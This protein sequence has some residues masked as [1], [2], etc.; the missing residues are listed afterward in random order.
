MTAAAVKKSPQPSP[1]CREAVRRVMELMAIRGVSGEETEVVAYL[2]RALLKA[3]LPARSI[4]RDTAHKKSPF[5]GAEG[6]LIIKLPGTY[7]APRRLFMAHLDTVPVCLGSKPVL[8]E[9][10]RRIRS[11]DSTTGLGAD[12]RAGTA[13]LLTTLL[14][15]L[16]HKRPHPPLTFL[17]LA[18]EEVGLIG[19][20]YAALGKLGKPAL[21][22]NFD[23]MAS[24]T[25]GATGA[26]RLT[27]EIAG[28][29]AHAGAFPEMGA[30]AVAI[31]GLAIADLQQNG[32]H[33][34]ICKGKKCGTSNIGIIEAGTATN[35]VAPRVR[36]AAEIRSHDRAFRK[37]ILSAY[38]KA[39]AKAAKLVKTQSGQYGSVKTTATLQY[40][41]F[42]LTSKTPCVVSATA[43][44]KSL[45]RT[46][47]YDV[48][49]AGLDA[50]W[51]TQHGVPTVTIGT[52]QENVHT[53]KE[54]LNVSIYE[55][56]CRA[57]LLLA[58]GR[59][60]GG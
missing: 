28:I 4:Q 19:M 27:V 58:T 23:G 15:I 44:F 26:Y 40:E 59:E 60:A 57:A 33:G 48:I 54:A 1:D 21:A 13:I 39:F 25:I 16:K 7:K 41:S 37:R 56:A 20:R 17:W 50:N 49:D 55:D 2:T 8:R 5:G 12:D 38:E 14:D 42:C 22:F 31:A 3:G 45:G 30:S 24:L 10:G 32:W 43:A 11:A 51:M 35:V 34:K 18:Q 52:G 53:I 47:T 36:L 9:R 46:P 6:N 29:A